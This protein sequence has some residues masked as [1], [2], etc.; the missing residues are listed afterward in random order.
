M[1]YH[2]IIDML[3]KYAQTSL[4]KAA[5]ERL[6]PVSDLEEVKRLLQATDEAFKVDRLK[7]APSFGGI[8][9]MMP[10]V[11]RARIGGTLN[12]HELLGIA[13]TLEGSRRVKRYI[14]NIHEDEPV[15]LLFTL[16]DMLS[17]QKTLEDQIKRCIDES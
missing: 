16:S 14:A 5:A 7:G 15:E 9:D 13:T 17:E 10:A 3:V 2:K 4:G 6:T 1:E 12:P 11:K 8:V